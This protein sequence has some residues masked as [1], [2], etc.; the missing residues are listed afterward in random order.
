VSGANVSGSVV[1]TK[2]FSIPFPFANNDID[3]PFSTD[4]D[5]DGKFIVQGLRGRGFRKFHMQA[6]GYR[7]IGC[8]FYF[9][10]RAESLFEEG[11][12]SS[13]DKPVVFDGW[14][15]LGPQKI[16]KKWVAIPILVPDG[17]WY[18]INL[19]ESTFHEGND[20]EGD[21]RLSIEIQGSYSA[22]SPYRW[23][24]KIEMLNGGMVPVT[25][26][27]PYYAPADGYQPSF[28]DDIASDGRGH[29]NRDP[30]LQSRYWYLKF[31]GDK[32]FAAA[33]LYPSTSPKSM[34]QI[35][36]EFNPTGSRDLEP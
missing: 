6:P 35:N 30:L 20:R 25:G 2:R 16:L 34:F 29:D 10:P 21:I 7:D 32:Y 26:H 4:T 19:L 1:S 8:G 9:P 14:K 18:V 13:W 5:A 23:K 3:L 12:R 27:F 24:F 15:S 33:T 31:R 22:D 11:R 36:Y 17:R 28:G